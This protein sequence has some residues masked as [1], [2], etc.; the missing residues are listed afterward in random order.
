MSAPYQDL[1]GARRI[2][3]LQGIDSGGWDDPMNR[4]EE[5]RPGQCKHVSSVESD[6]AGKGTQVL[7]KPQEDCVMSGNLPL[8]IHSVEN[9]TALRVKDLS[10]ALDCD[11]LSRFQDKF[12]ANVIQGHWSEF[13]PYAEK[14]AEW[15]RTEILPLE[16]L[17]LEK[18]V[19]RRALSSVSST[20]YHAEW[21]W[22]ESRYSERCA[23]GLCQRKPKPDTTPFDT[24][25][26]SHSWFIERE[27]YVDGFDF[28]VPRHARLRE[29]VAVWSIVDVGLGTFYSGPL[30]LGRL[31]PRH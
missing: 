19:G 15:I 14:L 31:V 12:D 2:A 5:T 28:H 13:E 4:V 8:P 1:V 7:V 21:K 10:D 30:I 27:T 3:P 25:F 18:P 6:E 29:Y 16:R 20:V 17:R 9:D 11:D 26:V 23:I 24:E 22:P